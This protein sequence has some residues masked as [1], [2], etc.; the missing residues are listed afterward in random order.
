MQFFS[1]STKT[2]KMERKCQ[3]LDRFGKHKWWCIKMVSSC[4]C[5]ALCRFVLVYIA[6]D[7]VRVLIRWIH[8]TP[9]HFCLLVAKHN[10]LLLFVIYHK[11]AKYPIYDQNILSSVSNGALH[12]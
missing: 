1:S 2:E 6:V 10:S 5:S 4:V 7:C 11:I 9:K 12:H 3:A 8:L